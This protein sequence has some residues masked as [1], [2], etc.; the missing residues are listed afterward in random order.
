MY[1]AQL[2]LAGTGE[3]W[4]RLSTP[5]L[6][7]AR[8]RAREGTCRAPCTESCRCRCRR[9]A[10]AAE[11][12]R[13]GAPFA[14][15]RTRREGIPY[16]RWQRDAQH[17]IFSCRCQGRLV[18]R[19]HAQRARRQAQLVAAAAWRDI[20]AFAEPVTAEPAPVRSGRRIRWWRLRRARGKR[21]V[22]PDS[23]ERGGAHE[24]VER[25]PEPAR[26]PGDGRASGRLDDW[27]RLCIGRPSPQERP[28]EVAHL[29]MRM[30]KRV[31]W[32][33]IATPETISIES[34][35]PPSA[36]ETSLFTARAKLSLCTSPVPH[37]PAKFESAHPL[38]IDTRYLLS[39]ANTPSPLTT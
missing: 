6:S 30:S 9:R 29:P 18:C 24:L 22:P 7:A 11:R 5:P 33:R 2:E 35:S 19:G 8:A 20:S 23:A 21:R 32:S 3:P 1:T 17:D 31:R 27:R 38:M 28:L 15:A 26:W 12:V 4:V 25:D 16:Q 13:T 34:T 39:L 36:L 10:T 14:G 37:H